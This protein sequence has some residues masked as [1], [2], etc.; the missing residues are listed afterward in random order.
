MTYQCDPSN[1][2]SR[3]GRE[4]GQGEGAAVEAEEGEGEEGEGGEGHDAEGENGG[5]AQEPEVRQECQDIFTT[6]IITLA[7]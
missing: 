7:S 4:D 2:G 1:D 6:H 3:P 5:S